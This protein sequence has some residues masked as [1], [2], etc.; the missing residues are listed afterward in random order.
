M[1]RKSWATQVTHSHSVLSLLPCTWFLGKIS[2]RKKINSLVWNWLKSNLGSFE[3]K[4]KA[5]FS[6]TWITL[7]IR[8]DSLPALKLWA[9]SS[10]RVGE[11][12]WVSIWIRTKTFCHRRAR[13]YYSLTSWKRIT[14][15]VCRKCQAQGTLKWLFKLEMKT[16]IP[17][18]GV[19]MKWAELEERKFLKV[20]SGWILT[21]QLSLWKQ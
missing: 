20:S 2:C 8:Q 4:I 17:F 14:W 21:F 1:C 9:F 10:S 16:N 3:A 18:F 6:L 5:I 12:V 13:W 11:T 19:L 15:S 7:K